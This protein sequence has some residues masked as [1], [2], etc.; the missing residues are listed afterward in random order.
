LSAPTVDLEIVNVIEE[1]LLIDAPHGARTICTADA[2]VMSAWRG[3]T[4]MKNWHRNL[5]TDELYLHRQG[6]PITIRGRQFEPETVVLE[7]NQCALLDRGFIHSVSGPDAPQ[8]V[9]VIV[10]RLL[11]KVYERPPIEFAQEL[12]RKATFPPVIDLTEESARF[13]PPYRYP[14]NVLFECEAYTVELHVRS[15][16][17]ILR[18]QTDHERDHVWYVLKGEV[19][20]DTGAE[21]EG[22][23]LHEEQL[24]KVSAG[25]HY[26]AVSLTEITVS[27]LFRRRLG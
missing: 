18:P 16:G 9:I 26:R 7:Q 3:N 14:Q 10:E 27:L 19:R 25:T 8:S 17:S 6:P 21:G 13:T 1:G 23:V 22:P 11:P 12:E 20:L 15:E 4:E 5:D 2:F 24:T